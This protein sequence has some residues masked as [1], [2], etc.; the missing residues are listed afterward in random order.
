[1]TT[2]Y[3]EPI[4]IYEDDYDGDYVLTASKRSQSP[5]A[6]GLKNVLVIL[7]VI[8][9]LIFGVAIFS[10]ILRRLFA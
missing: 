9:A 10:R 7:V 8:V 2:K 4:I 3:S 1:M 5:T 6:S